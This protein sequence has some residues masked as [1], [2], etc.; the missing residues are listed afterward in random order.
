MNSVNSLHYEHGLV[1][2]IRRSWS[3]RTMSVEL[4]AAQSVSSTDLILDSHDS[5][6]HGAFS[7]KWKT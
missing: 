7:C 3:T 6:G 2:N 4:V 1:N 5:M